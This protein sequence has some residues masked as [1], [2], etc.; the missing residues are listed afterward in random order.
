[1]EDQKEC[2]EIRKTFKKLSEIVDRRE[3]AEPR[4]IA[5]GWW[6]IQRETRG[7]LWK[8]KNAWKL[9]CEGRNAHAKAV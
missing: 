2:F 1:M 4:G 7:I 6:R 8:F 5:G 9:V 3:C